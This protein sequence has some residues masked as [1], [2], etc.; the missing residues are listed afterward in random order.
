MSLANPLLPRFEDNSA[1][2][3]CISSFV[4]MIVNEIFIRTNRR[5][6]PLYEPGTRQFEYGNVKLR[7]Y[8]L[9]SSRDASSKLFQRQAIKTAD[10]VVNES[11]PEVVKNDLQE[12]DELLDHISKRVSCIEVTVADIGL[13]TKR[14]T[15]QAKNINQSTNVTFQTMHRQEYEVRKLL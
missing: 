7:E 8:P 11:T 2:F 12:V 14:Q 15:E 6:S 10:I 4:Q 13:E 1:R 3:R 9:Q 5:V